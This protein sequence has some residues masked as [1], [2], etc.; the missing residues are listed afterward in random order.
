[1]K[2]GFLAT[3]PS[4]SRSMWMYYH[5]FLPFQELRERLRPFIVD[6]VPYMNKALKSGKNILIEGAQSNVLDIDFGEC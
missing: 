6:T 2:T 5:F 3:R 4:L 1:M